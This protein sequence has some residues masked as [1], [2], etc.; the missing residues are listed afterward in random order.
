MLPL[1]ELR[2]RHS[3]PLCQTTDVEPAARRLGMHKDTLYD[4]LR[5]GKLPQLR[6]INIG[7]SQRPRYKIPLAALDA[8][9][10]PLPESADEPN[11]RQP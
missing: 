8:L 4:L 5:A 6:A 11:D 2:A 9:L 3:D 1:L 10:G 7:T